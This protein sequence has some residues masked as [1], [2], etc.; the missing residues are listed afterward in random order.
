MSGGLLSEYFEG[1]AFKRLTAVEAHPE[2]SNQH[3]F[4]GVQQL[5]LLLGAAKA[6]FVAQFVYLTD[7][8][9]EVRSASGFVT[10][11]DARERHPTRTEHRLYFPT[12]TVSERAAEGDLAVIARR[13]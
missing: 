8:D 13:R 12:T 6:T 4:D 9:D 2:R 10:W 1:I 5:R 11:Y 3:E 7:D